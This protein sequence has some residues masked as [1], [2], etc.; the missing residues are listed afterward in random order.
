MI[1]E[2][3][4]LKIFIAKLFLRNPNNSNSSSIWWYSQISC[5][6]KQIIKICEWQ[7][8]FVQ[9]LKS[10]N[11]NILFRF[12]IFFPLSM[13]FSNSII[14]SQIFTDL[15]FFVFFYLGLPSLRQFH[16]VSYTKVVLFIRKK[17]YSIFEVNDVTTLTHTRDFSLYDKP[18]RTTSYHFVLKKKKKTS[19]LT[20]ISTTTPPCYDIAR[21]LSISLRV[22]PISAIV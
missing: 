5:K 17:K 7:K 18:H 19:T 22:S 15:L 6:I 20:R 10:T 1:P 12:K 8:K 14:P 2:L 11:K 3:C 21:L 9:S 16:T 13:V 4:Q